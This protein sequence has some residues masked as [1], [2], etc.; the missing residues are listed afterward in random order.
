MS[1]VLDDSLR[2]P[3][4]IIDLFPKGAG[5]QNPSDEAK[6]QEAQKKYLIFTTCSV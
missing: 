4:P 5:G 3:N 6:K 1:Y 2:K